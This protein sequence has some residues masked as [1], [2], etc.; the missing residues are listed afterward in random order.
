MG[1]AL[2]DGLH[3]RNVIQSFSCEKRVNFVHLRQQ[4]ANG[5]VKMYLFNNYL[6]SVDLHCVTRKAQRPDLGNRREDGPR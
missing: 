5:V 6:P 4:C 3:G 1:D 2:D